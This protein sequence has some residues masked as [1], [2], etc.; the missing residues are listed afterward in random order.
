MIDIS[1]RLK[2]IATQV[3]YRSIIDIGTDH[4]Y[5][6]IY[7]CQLDKVDYAIAA[8]INSGPL[9]KATQ[10]INQYKFANKITTVLSNGFQSIDRVVDTAVIAGMGG[11]LIIDILKNNYTDKLKQIVVQPQL[12]IYDVRK[13]LHTIGFSIDNEEMI[14]EQNKY[15][16][17]I[18][19]IKGYEQYDKEQYYKFGKILIEKK[20]SVLKENIVNKIRKYDIIIKELSNKGGVNATKRQEHL[21]KEIYYLEEVLKW[22]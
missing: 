4:G 16:N 7:L 11:N 10:N 2:T 14:I 1:K 17:I 13:F 20:S 18:S 21:K 19:A 6:P 15:Y 22:L 8:D 5:V 12:D 3:K 9:E